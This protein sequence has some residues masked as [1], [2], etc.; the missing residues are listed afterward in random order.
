MAESRG[1]P[2][3]DDREHGTYKGWNQHQVLGDE[4]CDP[5]R[6]AATKY[7][8]NWRR[9]PQGALSTSVT[10]RARSHALTRLKALHPE[11][12]RLLY[13]DECRILYEAEMDRLREDEV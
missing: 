1:S 5:C 13:Q 8:R 6:T 10:G 9:T 2:D 11:E 7:M 12:Y 3:V 4:M